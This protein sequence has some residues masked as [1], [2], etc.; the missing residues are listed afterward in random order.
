MPPL[1]VVAICICCPASVVS[2]P[3]GFTVTVVPVVA[4]RTP[5]FVDNITLLSVELLERKIKTRSTKNKKTKR[6]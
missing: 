5:L 6:Y 2:C 1:P 4:P 3:L